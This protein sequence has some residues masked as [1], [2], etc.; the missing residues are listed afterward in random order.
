MET[1]EKSDWAADGGRFNLVARNVTLKYAAI[2]VDM[3]IGVL[4]LPFNIAHLGKAAY[5]VWALAASITSYFSMMNLGY[6][7]AQEKFAAQYRARRDA[8]ALNETAST[9]FFVS[10]AIGIAAFLV[11][12][13]LA[14]NIQHLFKIDDAQAASGRRVLLIISAYV[15]LGFP[16]SVF[17]G[18]VNGFLR[19]YFNG[20]VAI[21]TSLCVAVVNVAVLLGGYGLVELVAATYAVR[22]L[23][24]LLYAMNAYRVFPLLKIRVRHFS[25]T[26]LGEVTGFSAFILIIDLANKLNY[27]T[28]ALV[29]GVFLGAL[30]VAAWAV[31][32]R[33]IDT[34]QKLANQLN[35]AL[36]PVIVLSAAS[37]RNDQLGSVL[38][39]GTRWSLAMIVPITAALLILSGD[40]IRSYVGPAFADSVPV[41]RILALVLAI[42]VGSATGTT[43]LKGAGRHRM[44]AWTN[45]FMAIVN[46][47]LSIVLVRSL[48]LTGVALGTLIPVAAVSVFVL[49][50]AACSRA[51][52]GLSDALGRGIWP[53]LWPAAPMA[54][55]LFALRLF[56]APSLLAVALEA[57]T[58]GLVYAACFLGIAIGSR[59]RAEYRI[60]LA[61]AI[62]RTPIMHRP[63][64]EARG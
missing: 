30:A 48:G 53:S 35:E 39:Q 49:F 52:L 57:V 10:S 23:S 1:G 64:E 38:L 42:R 3:V 55:A 51:E 36:F 21:A 44:L 41:I 29:I 4:L 45:A 33:V 24:F 15:A 11:G 63:V 34:A 19:N 37:G 27:S 46:L 8:H 17:G 59:E 9:L 62:G 13:I 56:L 12:L 32:Q 6:G 2:S 40:L 60:K 20:V 31:A 50:P 28:D 26:R 7:A 58:G 47:V 22:A 25:L 5:G 61:G 16:F 54:A 18:I 14:L 43:L